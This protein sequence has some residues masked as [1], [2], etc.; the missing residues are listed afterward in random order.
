V[1]KPL[2]V[3]AGTVAP[4]FGQVGMGT[5]FRTGMTLG[6]MIEQGFLKEVL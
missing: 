2:S 1:L 4:A 3:E 5:Q 6:E